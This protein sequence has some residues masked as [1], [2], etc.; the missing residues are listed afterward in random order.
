LQILGHFQS[1]LLLLL[2]LNLE[3]SF[4][5]GLLLLQ[6]WLLVPHLRL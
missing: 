3:L 2:R 6:W 4:E 1:I 5:L